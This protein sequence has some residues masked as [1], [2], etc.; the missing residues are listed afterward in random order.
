MGR[1]TNYKKSFLSD[2]FGA[3]QNFS[4]TSA[5]ERDFFTLHTYFS[6]I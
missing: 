2:V 6:Y 1:S 5:L 3:K 4:L